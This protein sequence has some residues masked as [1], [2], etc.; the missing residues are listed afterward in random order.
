[1]LKHL[2]LTVTNLDLNNLPADLLTTLNK[3]ETDGERWTRLG[4]D[5]AVFVFALIVLFAAFVWSGWVMFEG[6]AA[7]D[8]KHTAQTILIALVSGLVGYLVKK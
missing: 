1:L 3:K 4:N 8:D 6:S 5:V 2:A 7:A